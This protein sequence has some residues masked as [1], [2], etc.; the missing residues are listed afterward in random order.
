MRPIRFAIDDPEDL[1]LTHLRA[2]TF[3]RWRWTLESDHGGQ[4]RATVQIAFELV[5]GFQRRYP[6]CFDAV[7]VAAAKTK[8]RA[9]LERRVVGYEDPPLTWY[10]ERERHWGGPERV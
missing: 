5:Y 1:G 9:L 6:D 7:S 3:Q 8:G 4:V 10:V 2:G